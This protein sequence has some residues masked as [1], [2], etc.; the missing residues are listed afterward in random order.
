MTKKIWTNAALI[1]ALIITLTIVAVCCVS[2]NTIEDVDKVNT[3]NLTDTSVELEWKSVSTAKGY[4]VYLKS[5]NDSDFQ[6]Y[7]QVEAVKGTNKIAL[8]ELEQA[9]KY[10]I[11]VTAYKN[12]KNKTIESENHIDYSICT[13][14]SQQ[15]IEITSP[16]EGLLDIS[17][18]KND[19]AKGYVVQYVIGDGT[20][21]EDAENENIEDKTIVEKEYSGLK[22]DE[23][24]SVR[25]CSYIQ[26]NGEKVY[27]R[28][29]EVKSVKISPKIVLPATI[30]PNKPMVALT[31][32]DGPSYTGSSDK[33]LDVLEKYNA[34]ATFFMVG[35]NAQNNVDNLKRKVSL[36]CEIGNHSMT[37]KN[38]G[39]NVTV[40][41]ISD[42][43]NAIYNACGVYPTAF[44][45][46]GGM[47]T[48][49]IQNECSAENMPIYFWSLDTNDWKNRNCDTV[50][51]CVMN[52]VE[53]GDIILMHEIYDSTADAV[54]KIVPELI[55]Q[56]YQL[57]TC[58]ELV[59]A[60]TG[61]AP[62]AGIEYIT[63]NKTR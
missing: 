50:Y 23:T 5:K 8:T 42:C 25:A 30:D 36:G 2:A 26:F 52:N 41:D 61:A 20:S 39:K 57:V 17:L 48:G 24:Y 14:P 1:I 56:G 28:W 47:T 40:S 10:D 38:Y 19:N 31:F 29:S 7:T 44:R 63:A 58:Q 46:P 15:V 9:T 55:K 6:L 59:Y 21:F 54:E 51:N 60:K 32:D 49:L 34:R 33:I 43:S 18:T 35:T 53:D 12:K 27:G 16:D 62:K 4:N 13:R 45:S 3:L 11:F 22:V 37:H